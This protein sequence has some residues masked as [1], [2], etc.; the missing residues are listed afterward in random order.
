MLLYREKTH[1][2]IH[3]LVYY[4]RVS[5]VVEP[6]NNNI[7][8]EPN[9]GRSRNKKQNSKRHV[10]HSNVVIKIIYTTIMGGRENNVELFTF[11]SSSSVRI[12]Y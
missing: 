1:I 8:Q 3:H 10:R 2:Q 12:N 9:V 4:D 5:T 7:T 11:R 6:S